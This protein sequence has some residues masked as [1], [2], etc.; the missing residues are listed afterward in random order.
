[1][2]R[3]HLTSNP[4][5]PQYYGSFGQENDDQ[6][7]CSIFSD[8][9]ISRYVW[10]VAPKWK[11]HDVPVTVAN[12][13]GDSLGLSQKIFKKMEGFE[14]SNW[15]V[16]HSPFFWLN[17]NFSIFWWLN[18]PFPDKASQKPAASPAWKDTSQSSSSSKAFKCTATM[19]S[20][21][22][23]SALDVGDLLTKGPCTICVILGGWD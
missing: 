2:I 21:P 10:Y 8:K 11:L 22:F 18:S 15:R 3:H 7:S 23:S 20:P 12:V 9:P 16:P 17:P 6:A 5:M 13:A 1:M 4:N 19:L 14:T